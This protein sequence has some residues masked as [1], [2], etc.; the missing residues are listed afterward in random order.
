LDPK[1][2]KPKGEAKGLFIVPTVPHAPKEKLKTY[3]SN[4]QVIIRSEFSD[5][6]EELTKAFFEE[7]SPK[8]ATETALVRDL[9]AAQC[10]C[11]YAIRLQTTPGLEGNEKLMS[12]LRRYQSTNQTRF[13]RSLKMLKVIQKE[14]RR[15]A[16][17]K[18]H[19]VKPKRAGEY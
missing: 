8:G 4:G 9:A 2:S 16:L 3:T 14:H 12:T 18:L 19:V 17:R 5:R 13:K 1:E 11:E 15:E 10:R 6:L 7:H